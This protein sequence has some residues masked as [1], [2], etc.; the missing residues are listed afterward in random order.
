[1][2]IPRM[3]LAAA[4]VVVAL[5]GCVPASADRPTSE[6]RPSE[7]PAPSASATPEPSADEIV[8]DH[9]GFVVIDGSGSVAFD[10]RWVDE[11]EPAVDELTEVFD[12]D[13]V[14]SDVAGDGTH[15]ADYTVYTWGGF[16]LGDAVGLQGARGDY[17]RPSFASAESAAVGDVAIRSASGTAVGMPLAAVRAVQPVREEVRYDGRVIFYVD[18]LDPAA[19]QKPQDP[20][21]YF[22]GTTAVG[23]LAD[24]AESAVATIDS[25]ALTDQQF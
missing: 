7:T 23:V 20:M 17:W 2:T 10:H 11:I 4:A 14:L 22:E 24:D 1:M 18:P 13:P 19:L 15:I 16:A 25:P 8:I 6:S 12:S 5:S 3:V 9:S 21:E